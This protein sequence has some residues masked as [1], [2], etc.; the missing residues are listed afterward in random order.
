MN[1]PQAIKHTALALG[2]PLFNNESEWS[3]A[4]ARAQST[5]AP[6]REEAAFLLKHL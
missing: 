1:A 5:L 3:R 6:Y 4:K 2:K